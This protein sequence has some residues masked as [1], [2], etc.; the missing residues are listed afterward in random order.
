VGGLKR[1]LDVAKILI[2]DVRVLLTE[3]SRRENMIRAIEQLEKR[4]SSAKE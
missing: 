1:K 3:E 4:I 2:D